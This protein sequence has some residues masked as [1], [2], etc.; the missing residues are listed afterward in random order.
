MEGFVQVPRIAHLALSDESPLECHRAQQAWPGAEK[1]QAEKHLVNQQRCPRQQKS[2]TCLLCKDPHVSAV[3]GKAWSYSRSIHVRPSL[4]CCLTGKTHGERALWSTSLSHKVL[5]T[6]QYQTTFKQEQK[7]TF[8]ALPVNCS[9]LCKRA[10]QSPYA[11][12]STA[13]TRFGF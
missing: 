11:Y 7:V 2:T 5:F 1:Q 13:I 8:P 3:A 10:I 12:D 4:Q 9:H 6:S